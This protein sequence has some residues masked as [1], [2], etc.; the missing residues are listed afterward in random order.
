MVLQLLQAVVDVESQLRCGLEIIRLA[1]STRTN[2]SST[3]LHGIELVL[4][5]IRNRCI[6]CTSEIGLGNLGLESCDRCSLHEARICTLDQL[7][8]VLFSR[9][10]TYI[11]HIVRRFRS[12]VLL[13][14]SDRLNL[15]LVRALNVC[16][17]LT[18]D[19]ERT[20]GNGLIALR[21]SLTGCSNAI[22]SC[23]CSYVGF[24]CIPTHGSAWT[25]PC[26]R[27]PGQPRHNILN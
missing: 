12:D 14:I 26:A 16:L 25:D 6:Y 9:R 23:S 10:Q 13:L 27:Y 1:I 5:L 17:L 18:R 22:I 4:L 19:I 7:R 8:T 24:S 2:R 15:V 20:L 21:N 11:C 3:S